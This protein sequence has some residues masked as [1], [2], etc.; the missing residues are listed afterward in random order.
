MQLANSASLMHPASVETVFCFSRS[1]LETIIEQVHAKRSGNETI[2]RP[3]SSPS[4]RNVNCN[5]NFTKAKCNFQVATVRFSGLLCNCCKLQCNYALIANLFRFMRS[6][7]IFPIA[8]FTAVQCD[9]RAERNCE[10][11]ILINGSLFNLRRLQKIELDFLVINST[12]Q[13]CFGKSVFAT[14]FISFS[15]LRAFQLIYVAGRERGI[16][17]LSSSKLLHNPNRGC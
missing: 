15:K 8:P 10:K 5:I 12:L 2:G 3:T 4:S 6:A 16:N 14:L 1:G 7:C 11:Q 9:I 17:E 13:L